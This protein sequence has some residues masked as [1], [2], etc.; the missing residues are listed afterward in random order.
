[1]SGRGITIEQAQALGIIVPAAVARPAVKRPTHKQ[2]AAMVPPSPIRFSVAGE[3]VPQPRQDGR[4]VYVWSPKKNQKVAT[5]QMY[6]PPVREKIGEKPNGQDLYGPDRLQPWR[7]AIKRAARPLIRSTWFGPVVVNTT[8]F[9]PR[10]AYLLTPKSP[11]CAI[12]H[13]VRCDRD[14]LDKAV[15]DALSEIEPTPPWGNDA[16]V[17]TG[18]LSK[19]FV[20]KGCQPG[21]EIEIIF[22]SSNLSEG[23]QLT[24]GMEAA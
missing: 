17:Y 12:P 23:E 21:A 1:M 20:E 18:T 13:T 16:Q 19:W 11:S 14:N 5:V 7:E 22:Q 15:L 10:P 9:F 3:P 24:L 8:W 2:L 6:T 4:V